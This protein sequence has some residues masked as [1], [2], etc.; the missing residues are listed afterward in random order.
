MGEPLVRDHC[1]SR[2]NVAKLTTNM[3][4]WTPFYIT[5]CCDTLGEIFSHTLGKL[6]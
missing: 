1:I 5:L 3:P 6:A 2:D 4:F